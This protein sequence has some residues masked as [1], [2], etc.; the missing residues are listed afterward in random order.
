MRKIAMTLIAAATAVAVA[1]IPATAGNPGKGKGQSKVKAEKVVKGN[2]GN[3][4]GTSGTANTANAIAGVITAAE[5]STILDFIKT[6]PGALG[7]PKGLPPGIAK[8]YARGK[9]LPP[10]IAKRYL[11]NGL[12]TQ[13]PARPGHEWIVVGR[14]V[15]LVERAT[16]VVVDILK[17]VL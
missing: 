14:D 13:L 17:A 2:S 9:P 8:N 15:T 12:L 7:T 4:G 5:R 11:P 3:A 10:G 16:R 6:R 1:S